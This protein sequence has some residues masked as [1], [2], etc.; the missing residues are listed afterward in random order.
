MGGPQCYVDGAWV[1]V[2]E[3]RVHLF[4]SG[5]MYGDTLTETLRTF[6][7]EP[8]ETGLHLKRMRRSLALAR[9]E[10]P[11]SVDLGGL[12]TEAVRRDVE[13]HGGEELLVKLDVTRGHFDYY[14]DPSRSYADYNVLLHALAV[15]FHRF[16]DRYEAGIAVAYPVTRQIPSQS[17]DTRIKHRS[18]LYQAIAEWEASD[19]DRGAAALLLDVDGRVAEGTGWNVFAVLDGEVLTPSLDNCLQGVSRTVTIQLCR[20]RGLEVRE[21]TLWPYD[22]AVADEVFATATSYCILPVTRVQGRT[23]G[24]GQP[25]EVTRAL[26]VAWSERVG[27]DLAAQAR[28][29]AAAARPQAPVA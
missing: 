5:L 2:S 19:V 24:G 8:F 6:R 21:T 17:L 23:V 20:E 7:H 9:V 22:L 15:P 26:T 11:P 14:R 12:V 10:V 18:R 13:A 16:A 3:A 4:D 29:R 28:E 27:V 1:P 25:G